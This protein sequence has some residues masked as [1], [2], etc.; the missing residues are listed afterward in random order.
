[1]DYWKK[2]IRDI[3]MDLFNND[4]EDQNLAD[5]SSYCWRKHINFQRFI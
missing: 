3:D 4:I 1:M 5:L 2:N